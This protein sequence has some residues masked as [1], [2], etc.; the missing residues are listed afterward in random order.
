MVRLRL[1]RRQGRRPRPR[2]P[3]PA[4]PGPLRDRGRRQLRPRAAHRAYPVQ[5]HLP[6]TG[7]AGS[8]LLPAGLLPQ[9]GN[10]LPALPEHRLHRHRRDQPGPLL[11]LRLP[12]GHRLLRPES[13]AGEGVG[14]LHPDL[15]RRHRA[16]ELRLRP[17]A[18]RPRYRRTDRRPGGRRIRQGRPLPGHRH[19][20]RLALRPGQLEGHGRP[21]P[22][23]RRAPPAH[24]QR[25]R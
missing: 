15:W 3:R 4:R 23:R 24:Q 21:H 10:G 18:V 19:R 1:R 6:R 13:R 17:G 16:R 2:L 5:C 7:G 9:R 11:L 20:Q 8:R 12:A 22:V 25:S 14:P